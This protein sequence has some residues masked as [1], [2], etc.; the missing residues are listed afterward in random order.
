MH[1]ILHTTCSSNWAT[2]Q[3]RPAN[4]T[5]E[6]CLSAQIQ[7][8]HDSIMQTAYSFSLQGEVVSN[9]DELMSNFFAQADALALG[10]TP[11]ELRSE[12]VRAPSLSCTRWLAPDG[13]I[14]LSLMAWLGPP[15]FPCQRTMALHSSGVSVDVCLASLVAASRRSCLKLQVPDALIPHKTF[16]GNRPSSSIMLPDLSAY[17]TGQILALYEH[18]TAA[19]VRAQCTPGGKCQHAVS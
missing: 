6:S 5:Y 18:V 8:C 9:H 14:S 19:M 7:H 3:Q 11:I 4:C 1:V 12:N 16:T 2:Q 15:V 13:P 10:K 17:T